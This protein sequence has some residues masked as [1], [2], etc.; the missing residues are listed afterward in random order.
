MS[1]IAQWG[2]WKLEVEVVVVVVFIYIFHQTVKTVLRFARFLLVSCQ[3]TSFFFLPPR[4]AVPLNHRKEKKIQ[5]LLNLS[6]LCSRL[7]S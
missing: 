1:D 4:N 7:Q 3:I 6:S 2:E 5:S